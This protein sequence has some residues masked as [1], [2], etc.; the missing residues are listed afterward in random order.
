MNL[1][2]SKNSFMLFC[3]KTVKKVSSEFRDRPLT[4]IQTASFWIEYIVR[5]G[6]NALRSPT[7]DMPWW[8]VSLLDI[9]ALIASIV[10]LVLYVTIKILKLLSRLIIININTA[11][12]VK[13]N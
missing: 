6:K 3:R 1:F 7:V 8:Q 5:H 12:K 13:E 2:G 4:P 9:Y 10:L 11:S